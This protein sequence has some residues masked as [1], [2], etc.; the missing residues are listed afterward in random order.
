MVQ[1]LRHHASTPGG[2]GSVPSQGVKILHAMHP[3]QKMEEKSRQLKKIRWL[4]RW[5]EQMLADG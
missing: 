3:G 1:W 5:I 4:D 2:T